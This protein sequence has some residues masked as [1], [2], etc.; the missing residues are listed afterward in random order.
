MFT[1]EKPIEQFFNQVITGITPP[2][3]AQMVE[4][5]PW[6]HGPRK[7]EHDLWSIPAKMPDMSLIMRK[8]QINPKMEKSYKI[9]GLDFLKNG[10]LMT[11]KEGHRALS[12]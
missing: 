4:C 10:N 2:V 11:H 6:Y 9:T 12:D 1:L 5:A 7:T 8:H 3:K